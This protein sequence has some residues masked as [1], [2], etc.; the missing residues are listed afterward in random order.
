MARKHGLGKI[1]PAELNMAMD[2]GDRE[3]RRVCDALPS[4]IESAACKIGGMAVL[5][6]VAKVLT[7]GATQ[8]AQ[9][10][11]IV[12]PVDDCPKGMEEITVKGGKNKRVKIC[13]LG[14][15]HRKYEPDQRPKGKPMRRKRG[16][17]AGVITRDIKN[18][19]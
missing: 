6:R 7:P 3:V 4:H 8:P 15:G 2:H 13:R 9:L 19:D 16:L 12:S 10:G 5:G 1:T 14:P 18:V 11:I 17:R